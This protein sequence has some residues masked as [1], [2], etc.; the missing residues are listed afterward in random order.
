MRAREATLARA[1]ADRMA[2]P[3]SEALSPAVED[4]M[5]ATI[6]ELALATPAPRHEPFYGLDRLGGPS[7]RLL[8]RLTRHGDFR[9]YVV[10]L[11]PAAGLGGTARWLSLRYACRVVALDATPRAVAAG[12]RLTRRARMTA[13][14][15]GVAGDLDGIPLRD[16]TCTQIWSVEALPFAHDL[17]RAVGELFRVLRPG[18][19]L[20]LQEVVRRTAA[21]P[22]LD[23]PWRHATRD[24]CVAA[25]DA[26]GFRDLEVE[27]VTGERVETSSVVLSARERL[28]RV[29][30]ARL[31]P[32]DP[33]HRAV[34]LRRGVDAV[35]GGPDYRVVHCFAR[36]PSV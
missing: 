24:D 28:D 35:L 29:L 25:L 8:D 5:L 36:R 23:G 34:A 7:L 18:C 6:R 10:V 27:D 2:D 9:K 14:A 22:A 1:G 16:G 13:R 20:A 32:D 21:V 3:I 11:V 4:A 26:V 19:T 15:H 33:W 12:E 31:P 17:R 30:A